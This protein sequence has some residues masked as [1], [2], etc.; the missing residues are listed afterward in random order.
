M[1]LAVRERVLDALTLA[2]GGE[3]GLPSPEDARDLPVT[4]VQDA[5][6]SAVAGG[7]GV[8]RLQMPVS[9][10]RA[11]AATST[12]RAAMRA[13]AHAMLA[14]LVAA[15]LVDSTLGGLAV[16]V[17]YAGGGISTEVGKLVWAEASFVVTYQ[18]KRGNL[19]ILV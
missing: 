14:A 11:E 15:A 13:Q 8:T 3:Y 16:S 10:A 7:Y 4:I 9:V 18:H 2:V 5:A 17:E 12:S 19:T 6:D 1:T